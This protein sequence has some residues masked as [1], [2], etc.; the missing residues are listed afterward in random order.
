MRTLFFLSILF[1]SAWGIA[2]QD[3]HYSMWNENPAT[4]NAGATGVMNEDVRLLANY[5]M[6][7]LTLSGLPFNS[8]TFSLDGK[9]KLTNSYNTIGVGVNFT[10]DQ[11]GDTR[12]TSNIVSVPVAFNVALD[13][14]NFISV[15]LSPGF[16]MQSV[17]PGN[18][19]WDNQWNGEEFDQSIPNPEYFINQTS[20][21]DMGAGIY[22]QYVMDENTHVKGGISMNH[23]N[24][25]KLSYLGMNTGIFRN[26]NFMVSGNKFYTLRKFG[27]SPQALFSFYG[28]NYNILLGSYFD[29]ELFESSERTDYVQRSF[30]SYGIFMRWNDALIGSLAYKFNAFKIGVSYDLNFSPLRTVT[31]SVGAV[32]FFLKYSALVDRRAYIHDRKLFRWRGR[33]T[34]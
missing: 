8:G 20:A 3:K 23:I 18:Q 12:F 17:T 9:I 15:G 16:Y 5:R 33:N 14:M 21:F 26:I 6:Q 4:L 7:W 10:N 19:T 22:Y 2:Q 11:T 34:M 25:P 24:G 31:N 32:E 28:P 29:H 27:I 1:C 13:R 30:L